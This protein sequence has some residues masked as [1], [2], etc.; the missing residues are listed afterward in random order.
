MEHQSVE[1]ALPGILC[2]SCQLSLSAALLFHRFLPWRLSM[3]FP[4]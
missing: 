3:K 2:R 4:G 1:Q